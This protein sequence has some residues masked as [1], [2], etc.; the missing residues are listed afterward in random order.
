M[1]TDKPVT[2]FCAL[3]FVLL[4]ACGQSLAGE[5]AALKRFEGTW[6]GDGK[7]MGN[8][9]RLELKYEW[10]LSGKFLRLSMKN[11]SKT[12]S[13]EGQVFEGHA[14]YGAQSDGALSGTWFDSRGV[15]FA[16]KG[17][18]EGD[19]LT[20]L[21]GNGQEQGKSLYR[22]VDAGTLEVTDSVQ[23]KD[24]TFRQFASAIVKRQ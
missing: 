15:S 24:G 9:A 6:V 3:L 20:I 18:F 14:Y 5:S 10:V 11:E 23:L 8:V 21:W 2:K 4:L 13:G 17:S 7:F 19:A 1:K 22:L 12:P 16:V